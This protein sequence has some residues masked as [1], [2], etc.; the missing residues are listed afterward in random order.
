MGDPLDLILKTRA[1]LDSGERLGADLYTCGPLFTAAGGHGTE[2]FKDFPAMVRKQVEEQTVRTPATAEE[3]RQQVRALKARGVDCIK[4]VLEA[5]TPGRP[6]NRMD[7]KIFA[8]V[9][10][11]AHAQGLRI[12]VHTGDSKDV[13]EAVSAGA[14]SIEHGSF[15]DAIPDEVF[16]KMRARNIAYD[17]TLAVAEA[18][19]RMADGSTDPLE[20]PLVPQ[21]VPGPL[22]ESTKKFVESAEGEKMRERFKAYG[23]DAGLGRRNLLRAYQLGVTLVTGS[24]AGNPLVFH[25]PAIHRELQLWVEAGV[26]PAAALQAAT[27]NSARV[28]GGRD[29]RGL[30]KPGY[31]ADILIVDGNPIKD[32]KQT[33]NISQVI[34]GGERIQRS[35]LFDQ[36]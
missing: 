32:I 8:A 5:G 7:G 27:N 4:A 25:G 6:F 2:Y 17:P 33:A 20:W 16:V 31:E 12:A 10:E 22:M 36:Q 24:D 1:T 13:A 28:L 23:I 3:A 14:N 21:V 30:I 35:G 19:T 15:R 9:A 34:L 18:V 11:E 26:D 29:R